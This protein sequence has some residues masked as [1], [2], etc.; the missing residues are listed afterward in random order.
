[1]RRIDYYNESHFNIG[2][3]EMFA[4]PIYVDFAVLEAFTA[5][6]RSKKAANQSGT[7]IL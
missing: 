4:I 2:R 5:W 6:E 7:D 3:V 1:M